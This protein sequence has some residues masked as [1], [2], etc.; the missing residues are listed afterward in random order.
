M[1]DMLVVLDNNMQPVPQAAERWEWV[2][3]TTVRFYLRKDL[4]FS[5]GDKLTADDVEFTVNYFVQTKTPPIARFRS[6]AGAKKVDDYTVDLF[7]SVPDG[8]TLPATIYMIIVPAKYFQSVGTKG[9][10]AAPIGSGPYVLAENQPNVIQRFTKRPD[11][12]PFRKVTASEIDVRSMPEAGPVVAGLQTGDIDMAVTVPFLP[13]QLDA[14]KNSGM[15]IRT[16]NTGVTYYVIIWP[17]WKRN[18]TPL[19]D[20]RVREAVNYAV[21]KDALSKKL[22]HGDAKPT[23][24][25]V[26]V[27]SQFYDETLQPYPYDPAKAKQ[28]LAEAGYPNGFTL[29]VGIDFNP[30]NSSADLALAVQGYLR[31]V[32]ITTPVNNVEYGAFVDEFNGVKPAGDFLG[33]GLPDPDGFNSAARSYLSCYFANAPFYCNPEFD[34]ISSLAAAETD[35]TK[36]RALFLQSLK[37]ITDDV[38]AIY[39][40]ETPSYAVLGPKIKGFI[41]GSTNTYLDNYEAAYRVE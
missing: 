31:D 18:N 38:P 7:N 11:G 19:A 36:R 10:A 1:F 17:A 9:F 13:E 6:I 41:E 23:R 25:L 3:P 21:D 16:K 29:P 24:N 20:K 28:L 39:L 26:G 2:N 33:T 27:G 34:R 12:H 40:L 5:N 22:F 35:A 30:S 15:Q 32:G 14:L 8:S 4:T 37:V